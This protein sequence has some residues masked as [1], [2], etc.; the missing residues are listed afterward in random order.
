MPARCLIKWLNENKSEILKN[1]L[2]FC[3]HKALVNLMVNEINIKYICK[4][5]FHLIIQTGHL[6]E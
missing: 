1:Y 2:V 4:C 3:K 6:S 5:Y